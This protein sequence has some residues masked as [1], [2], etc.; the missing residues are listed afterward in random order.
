MDIAAFAVECARVKRLLRSRWL[1]PMGEQQKHL[2]RLRRELTDRHVLLA[3]GRGRLHVVVP[4]RA[5]RDAGA[6]W[7]A[8]SHAV[9]IAERLAPD[10]PPST[11][12]EARA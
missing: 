9:R 1:C 3:W 6:A 2:A 10:Y 7:T 5:L 11:Q 4:P 12:T 8:Q